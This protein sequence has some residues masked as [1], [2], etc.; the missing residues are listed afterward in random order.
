MLPFSLSQLLPFKGKAL[1]RERTDHRCSLEVDSHQQ[2]VSDNWTDVYFLFGKE[3]MVEIL[4]APPSSQRGW[5]RC[6][7]NFIISYP[8]S[9]NFSSSIFHLWNVLTSIWED[10]I[11][12]VELLGMVAPPASQWSAKAEIDPVSKAL[13]PWHA[14]NPENSHERSATWA[15]IMDVGKTFRYCFPDI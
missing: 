11:I 3:S 12:G 7:I 9:S 15:Y 6:S 8:I 5:K 2:G 14:I 10:S 13:L 1:G 4:F